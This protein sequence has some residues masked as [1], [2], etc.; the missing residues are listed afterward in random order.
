MSQDFWPGLSENPP[1]N[2]TLYN[3]A[4][5]EYI[6][7]ILEEMT[8]RRIVRSS[9][10]PLAAWYCF[11]G[12]VMTGSSCLFIPR[13]HCF[14]LFCSRVIHIS[15]VVNAQRFHR[16]VFCAL[17][18]LTTAANAFNFKIA[19]LIR[20]SAV[21]LRNTEKRRPCDNIYVYIATFLPNIS[22]HFSPL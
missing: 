15:E 5:P 19:G 10:L 12:D 13:C 4:K 18:K 20:S 3:V 11:C 14:S 9:V 2:K 16:R 7:P 22:P 6:L 8:L 21:Y 1:V 17:D